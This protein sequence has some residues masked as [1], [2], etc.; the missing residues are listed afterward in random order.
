MSTTPAASVVSD[1]SGDD[2]EKK[3][4][5]SVTP[6]VEKMSTTPAASVVSD[7][8]DD[9]STIKN[10]DNELL[11]KSFKFRKNKTIETNENEKEEGIEL[12]FESNIGNVTGNDKICVEISEEDESTTIIKKIDF[13][14]SKNQL[15]VKL[16]VSNLRGKPAKIKNE[17]NISPSSNVYKY[18]DIKLTSDQ[19]YIGESGIK[20][21]NFTFTINSSW[22]NDNDVDKDTVVM[23]RYHND[24][25]QKLNTT[26]LNETDDKMTFK[27]ITSGLSIF[28]VVGDKVVEDS[29]EIIVATT[30][31]P[32]WMP[33][34]IILTSSIMLGL[35]IFKKRFV[36]NP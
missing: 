20:S 26:F 21:M 5:V 4:G 9:I 24:T 32:W 18:L 16:K 14:S 2:S 13:S 7:L 28:A 8:S 27:A 30:N 6:A 29:D 17:L 36:Y 1:D 25:W 34:T 10:N 35:V 31:V 19:E 33:A 12:T 11:K 3:V 22:I 15:N 23:M